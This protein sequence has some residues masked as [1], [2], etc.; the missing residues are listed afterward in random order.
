MDTAM[1]ARYAV[2]T[3]ATRKQVEWISWMQKHDAPQIDDEVGCFYGWGE[4][5]EWRRGCIRQTVLYAIPTLDE[6]RWWAHEL[7]VHG[8]QVVVTDHDDWSIQI[9]DAATPIH[10]RAVHQH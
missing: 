7:M 9:T 4:P 6:A 5:V 1:T 2:H 10:Y 8:H 3:T